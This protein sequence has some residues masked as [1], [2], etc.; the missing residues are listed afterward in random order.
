MPRYATGT[1]E[2]GSGYEL[3]AIADYASDRA[4]IAAFEADMKRQR[5]DL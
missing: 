4:A 3:Y 2:A 5:P 1:A